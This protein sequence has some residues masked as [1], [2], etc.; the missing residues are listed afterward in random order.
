MRDNRTQR[1]RK[2]VKKKYDT[3]ICR[4]GNSFEESRT[5]IPGKIHTV[6]V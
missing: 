3:S 2:S 4:Y 1:K 5:C 6:V